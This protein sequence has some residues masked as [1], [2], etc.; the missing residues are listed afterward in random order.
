M[1][2]AIETRPELTPS[3]E[4]V[5]KWEGRGFDLRTEIRDPSSGA[6]LRKQPYRLVISKNDGNYFIR[7]GKRYSE[8][9]QLLDKPQ[10]A[11]K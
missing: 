2:T 11:E 1:S 7:D 8:S 5:L 3:Q 9:G 10:K 4:K 6:V